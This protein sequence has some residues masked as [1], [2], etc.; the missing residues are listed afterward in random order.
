MSGALEIISGVEVVL[1]IE[2]YTA[3][4]QIVAGNSQLNYEGGDT[5]IRSMVLDG[6]SL[7]SQ[8]AIDTLFGK[9]PENNV[10]Y[11]PVVNYTESDGSFRY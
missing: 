11:P 8:Q 1:S 10:V 3:K 9:F 5:D 6:I 7:T 2:N 4:I